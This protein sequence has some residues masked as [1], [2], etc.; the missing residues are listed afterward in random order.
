MCISTKNNEFS[1]KN[2]E[3]ST[4]NIEF[5]TKNIEFSTKCAS[6]PKIL[7][8]VPKILKKIPK[9]L[10][11][12]TKF[13]FHSPMKWCI[14]EYT[15]IIIRSPGPLLTSLLSLVRLCQCKFFN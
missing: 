12:S 6:V 2:I 10:K 13:F 1:T 3:F 14:R 11:I 15:S 8:S 4:K 9:I 5:S 7:N